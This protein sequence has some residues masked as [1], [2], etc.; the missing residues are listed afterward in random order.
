MPLLGFKARFAP[1][2]ENGVAAAARRAI[3]NEGQPIKRQTIRALRKDG[4]DPAP[5]DTLHLYTGLRTKQARLLGEVRCRAVTTLRIDRSGSRVRRDGRVLD[6][7][8]TLRLAR[9]DGF[10]DRES[11]IDFVQKM[12]GL[13]FEGLLIRW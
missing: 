3:P 13:P 10:V 6:R 8:A 9:A 12:H 7:A 5:G 11:M 1:M 4:R 2:V